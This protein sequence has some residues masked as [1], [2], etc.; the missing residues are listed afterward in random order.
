MF[1][2][3]AIK[4][5]CVEWIIDNSINKKTKWGLSI[6]NSPWYFHSLEVIRNKCVLYYWKEDFII[7]VP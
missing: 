1:E 4:M 7:E 5:C 6:D 2:I 3:E